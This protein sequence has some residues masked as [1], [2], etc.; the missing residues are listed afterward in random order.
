[1]NAKE[2]KADLRKTMLALRAAILPK[3]KM[4][5]DTALC[6]KIE[7]LIYDRKIQVIHTYLP[8]GDEPDIYPLIQYLLTEKYKIVCPKPKSN[9]HMINLELTSL[10]ELAEGRYG[11]KH[12]AN[13]LEYTG[14]IDL[15]IVPGIAFDKQHHR[16]GFGSGYY[17]TYFAKKASGYK[18][19]ICYPF[20]VVE[21]FP[22]EIHDVPLDS[23]FH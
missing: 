14:K 12:P 13:N 19:G 7:S 16:L 1:M 2:A 8:F 17:D 21:D 23:V 11:T 4:E 9:R 20:Q 18:L 22:V 3:E 5:L 10:A 6:S 15:F